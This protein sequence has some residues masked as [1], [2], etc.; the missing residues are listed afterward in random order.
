MTAD[1]QREDEILKSAG[2]AP[3]NKPGRIEQ[4]E[5]PFAGGESGPPVPTPSRP[6]G[7]RG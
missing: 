2:L 1:V 3:A 5:L 4:M 6:R 7:K